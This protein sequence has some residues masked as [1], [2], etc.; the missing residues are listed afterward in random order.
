MSYNSPRDKHIPIQVHP[1]ALKEEHACC[2]C[3]HFTRSVAMS[4]KDGI[5][6][7]S[8]HYVTN[9]DECSAF[10]QRKVGDSSGT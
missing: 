6:G 2:D 10:T 3:V 5:C 9:Y 4:L 8:G 7:N 1:R